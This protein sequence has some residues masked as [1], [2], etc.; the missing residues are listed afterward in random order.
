MLLNNLGHEYFNRKEYAQSI[1]CHEKALNLCDEQSPSYL[2]YLAN[3]VD[4]CLEGNLYDKSFLC[5]Q[6][7]KGIRLARR[8]NSKHYLTLF[9]LME[10]KV[11]GDQEAYYSYIEKYALPQFAKSGHVIYLSRY[12]K[13]LYQYYINNEKYKQASKVL[14]P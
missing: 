4:S 5:K 8:W 9:R 6:I 13:V 12:K 11:G 14:N 1:K 7:K 2:L 3:Y 10:F